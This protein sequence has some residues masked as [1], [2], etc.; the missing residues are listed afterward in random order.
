[1]VSNRRSGLHVLVE[2]RVG[3]R[4]GGRRH[5]VFEVDGCEQ[6]DPRRSSGLAHLRVAQDP[7]GGGEAV[8][9]RHL[10]VHQH[11]IRALP[12]QHREC[13]GAVAG[14]T[15]HDEL[16]LRPDQQALALP[17]LPRVVDEHDPDRIG[18]VRRHRASSFTPWTP[19]WYRS[20]GKIAEI[21]KPTPGTV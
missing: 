21:E 8:D 20:A 5:V 2:H 17:L 1:M 15:D 18:R 19:L 6:H 13:L 12:A 4:D 11:D 7:L 10:D 16:V 9:A 14:L 3:A